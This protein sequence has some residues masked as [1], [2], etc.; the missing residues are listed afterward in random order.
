MDQKYI[1]VVEDDSVYAKILQFKLVK[2]GY[3]VLV[4]GNGQ[5]ALEALKQRKPDLMVLD[6]I[7]PVKDG[8]ETLKELRQTDK[9]LKVVIA[10]SLGQEEDLK[11]CQELGITAYFVKS[12]TSLYDL[13]QKIKEYLTQ[14]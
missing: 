11:K 5:E 1:I 3:D 10:S 4:A 12:D 7:M 8:F 13:M 2:E 14:A 9:D 6:L